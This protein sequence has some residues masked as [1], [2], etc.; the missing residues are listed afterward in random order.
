M[1]E[2]SIK[3]NGSGIQFDNFLDLLLKDEDHRG[4]V[5]CQVRVNRGK[6]EEEVTGL[7]RKRVKR[8][9][10]GL[11]V[12]TRVL[13]TEEL[14]DRWCEVSVEVWVKTRTICKPLDQITL[15]DLRPAIEQF[16]TEQQGSITIETSRLFDGLPDP[17]AV[18]ARLKQV[19]SDAGHS[20]I[21][22]KT[23]RIHWS[24][25]L[26]LVTVRLQPECAPQ[27]D[28]GDDYPIPSPPPT[29]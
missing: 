5:H 29:K 19:L 14:L 13:G 9:K 26:Q 16:Q 15:R 21:D 12:G 1:V 8:R 22:V 2:R 25:G 20:G 6:E 11:E 3:P 24:P 4:V 27:L 18:P 17:Q 7:I 23:R 28:M 10:G